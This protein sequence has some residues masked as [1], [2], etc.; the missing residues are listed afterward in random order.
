[1]QPYILAIDQGTTNS[2]ALIFDRSGNVIS[3]HQLPLTQYFPHPGWVEQDAEEMLQNTINCCREALRK[4]AIAVDAIAAMGIANQRE[5]TII[6]D[7]ITGKP[8]Y[9]AIVWQDRRTSDICHELATQQLQQMLQEKTGLVLDPYFSATKVMWLLANVPA[10]ERA[11]KAGI[12]WYGR[13]FLLWHLSQQKRMPRSDECIADNVLYSYA[14]RTVIFYLLAYPSILYFCRW[15]NAAQFGDLR[16][17]ISAVDP[18]AGM[19]G[20]QQALIGQA[21]LRRFM[22]KAMAP[23][24]LSY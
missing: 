4:A 13:Y 1:M 22:V 14:A 6:W 18:I 19:A 11:A 21:C 16:A 20:D 10:R 17:D 9:R 3:E 24:C 15:D 2:R 8:I 7:K 12:I 5:T 23:A